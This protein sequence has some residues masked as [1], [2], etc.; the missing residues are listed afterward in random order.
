M[1]DLTKDPIDEKDKPVVQHTPSSVQ[2]DFSTAFSQH[3]DSA[4]LDVLEEAK[5]NDA[6]FV[7][8]FKEKLKDATLKLAEVERSKAEAENA[9]AELARKNVE[10]EKELVDTKQKL[11]AFEQVENKWTNKQRAREYHYNGVKNVMQ[12]IG[13]TEPMCIPLLYVIFP[14]ALVFFFIKCVI[15]ATVGNLL[16]GAV[17]SD[18]PKAMRGFLW[19]IL[20]F[21]VLVAVGLGGYFVLINYIL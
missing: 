12:C 8:E 15:Q 11:N 18:R 2:Q 19:T 21:T 7:A 9:K 13:I 6:K 10:Y 1:N 16:C 17:N 14:I 4:K 20:V 5:H 3:V